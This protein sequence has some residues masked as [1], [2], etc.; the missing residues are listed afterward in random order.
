LS[1]LWVLLLPRTRAS[2]GKPKHIL[3]LGSGNDLG[4]GKI[5]EGLSKYFPCEPL[6]VLPTQLPLPGGLVPRKLVAGSVCAKASRGMKLSQWRRHVESV[7]GPNTPSSSSPLEESMGKAEPGAPGLARVEDWTPGEGAVL[8]LPSLQRKHLHLETRLF[9]FSSFRR[10][11]LAQESIF[12]QASNAWML[13]C[14]WGGLAVGGVEQPFQ[15][16]SPS[17]NPRGTASQVLEL[18]RI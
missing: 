11:Q 9:Q 13:R 5:W 16:S 12:H 8:G 6:L 1:Q 17:C 14:R 18:T 3:D 15:M 2:L 7:L 10:M 4:S